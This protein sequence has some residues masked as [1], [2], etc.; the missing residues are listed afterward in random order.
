MKV[1]YLGEDV[2]GMAGRTPAE[3]E[4]KPA[5]APGQEQDKPKAKAGKKGIAKTVAKQRISRSFFVW[6]VFH[7]GSA[8]SRKVLT[9][10]VRIRT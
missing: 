1:E 9:G 2:G 5:P 8:Y 7:D 3:A 6:P 4:A 10:P